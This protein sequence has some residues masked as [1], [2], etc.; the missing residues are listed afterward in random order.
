MM[1]PTTLEL[2]L[3]RFGGRH[4]ISLAEACAIFHIDVKTYR[5][6]RSQNRAP[7]PAFG[8]P[9]RVDLRDIAQALDELRARD[10]P[11]AVAPAAPAAAARRGRGRPRKTAVEG[12][13]A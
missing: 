1:M 4:I 13:A 3:A 6:Y 7:F 10:I 12:G 11:A 2:L 9:L 8:R 5:N